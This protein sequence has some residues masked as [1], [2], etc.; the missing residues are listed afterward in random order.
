VLVLERVERVSHS[1]RLA[2]KREEK[3]VVDPFAA[4]KRL[5]DN[6]NPRKDWAFSLAFGG[7]SNCWWACTPRFLPSDFRMRSK[8]GVGEDWPIS[9]VDLQPYYEEVEEIFDV[10]GPRKTPFPKRI[11]YPQPPHILTTVD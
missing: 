7:S 1:A 5:F 3:L 10:S 2:S 8:Y 6:P 9:Y 11:P 4:E